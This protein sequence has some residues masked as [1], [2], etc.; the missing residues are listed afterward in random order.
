MNKF[1]TSR[2]QTARLTDEDHA[3]VMKRR[4]PALTSMLIDERDD[5]SMA[6]LSTPEQQFLL[7]YVRVGRRDGVD[8]RGFSG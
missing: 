3:L 2:G 7:P 4:S 6:E 8:Y 5:N 1:N